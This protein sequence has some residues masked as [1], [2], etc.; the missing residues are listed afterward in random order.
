MKSSEAY[1]PHGEQEEP[2]EE[3]CVSPISA[4]AVLEALSTL[5]NYMEENFGKFDELYTVESQIQER[6]ATSALRLR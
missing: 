2:E 4:K 3:Q 1:L 6:N 5:R